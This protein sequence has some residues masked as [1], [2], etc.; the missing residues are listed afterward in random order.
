MSTSLLKK[1][2]KAA[3]GLATL[4][5]VYSAPAQADVVVVDFDSAPTG[6]LTN[7]YS[8]TAGVTFSGGGGSNGIEIVP[9]SLSSTTYPGLPSNFYNP[10]NKV[11]LVYSPII[12]ATFA[13]EVSNVSM[14][15][16]DTELGSILGAMTA[17][18]FSGHQ[19]GF[20]NFVLTPFTTYPGFSV[21]SLNMSGIHLIAFQTDGDGAVVDNLTFTTVPAPGALALLGLGL[22]GI[23]GLRRNRKAA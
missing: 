17:F 19:I 12:F 2:S 18:D 10:G 15:F 8:S 11:G 14:T 21:L 20:T 23:G 16:A 1:I 22:F 4:A 7:F 3:L 6:F 9:Y 5:A 13:N